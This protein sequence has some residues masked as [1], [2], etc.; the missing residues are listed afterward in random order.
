MAWKGQNTYYRH[1]LTD[2]SH[3]VLITLTSIKNKGSP[4]LMVKFK[5]VIMLPRSD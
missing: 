5:D 1:F 3:T 4:K 2:I